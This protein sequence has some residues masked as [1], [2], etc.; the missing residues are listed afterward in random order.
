MR[1]QHSKV[2]HRIYFEKGGPCGLRNVENHWFSWKWHG[3]NHPAAIFTYRWRAI[4]N[5]K[6]CNYTQDCKQYKFNTKKSFAFSKHW[7]NMKMHSQLWKL[8]CLLVFYDCCTHLVNIYSSFWDN[9]NCAPT[10]TKSILPTYDN[11]S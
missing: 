7:K 4:S 9:K 10:V 11:I 3:V 6:N 8:Y 1:C 2:V 5:C